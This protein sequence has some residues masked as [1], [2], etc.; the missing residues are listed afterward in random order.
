M[1]AA[2]DVEKLVPVWQA[3]RSAAPV[4][5]IESESDYDRTTAFLNNLLDLVRDDAGHPLYSL[6]SVVGD[7]IEAYEID[8]EPL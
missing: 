7:L 3:L 4:S 8:H 5:H 2:L 6:I 1:N